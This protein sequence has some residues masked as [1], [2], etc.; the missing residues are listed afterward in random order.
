MKSGDR[1]DGRSPVLGLLMTNS[2][3]PTLYHVLYSM[4]LMD[5]KIFLTFKDPEVLAAYNSQRQLE[6]RKLSA[7]L[8]AERAIF[9]LIIVI[10]YFGHPISV[11]P[12]RMIY[13]ALGLGIHIGSLL[14][15]RLKQNW[16]YTLH[17]PIVI[18]SH[19]LHVFNSKLPDDELIAIYGQ[20]II[21]IV[22]VMIL[23]QNWMI[24]SIGIILAFL[25]WCLYLGL[26]CELY[27]GVLAP[28]F[29]L[30]FTVLTIMTYFIEL[31]YKSE[32]L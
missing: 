19:M 24:T 11:N 8:L 17:A 30:L 2:L 21:I 28:Q 12:M 5:S 31:K 23:N 32:F 6:I 25:S 1:I 27:V 9:L 15:L 14:V 18:I 10:N 29:V 26:T 7:L 16:L 22:A 20:M 13:F 4:I 3:Q